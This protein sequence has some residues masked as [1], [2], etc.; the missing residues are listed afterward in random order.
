MNAPKLAG[1]LSVRLSVGG[2]VPLTVS[3]STS[4]PV[5]VTSASLPPTTGIEMLL[6]ATSSVTWVPG[7]GRTVNSRSLLS[8]IRASRRPAGTTTSLGCR[9]KSSR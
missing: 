8:T 1:P 3:S 5:A 7:A 2:T 9:S 6:P 4:P